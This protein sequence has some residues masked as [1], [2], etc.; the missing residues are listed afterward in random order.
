MSDGIVQLQ[1]NSSGPKVDASE[2][3]VGTNIVERQRINISDATS[4][5]GLAGVTAAN[6]LQV[7]VTRVQGTIASTQSGAWNVT[8]TAA[9]PAGANSI[10]VVQQAA[11]V[12]GAQ[13]ATG[14]S[15]QDLKDAGRTPI[16]LYAVA[17][18]A[19]ATGV[20]TAISLTKLSGV[21]STVSGASFVISA[22]KTFRITS[23]FLATRGSATA[24]AQSTTF[25]FRLNA[26]GAVTTTSAP[27]FLQ[28]RSVTPAT[29]SAWD[30]LALPLP[31]G[32]EIVGNGTLQIGVTAIS[33]FVTNAP[34]LDVLIT[35]YEY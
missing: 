24:T 26:T 2:L 16:V 13:G 23:I 4:A 12:K 27:V 17:A 18:V 30:R 21:A 8:L 19:G 29:A 6:G 25:S 31:D 20:E 15:T 3:T 35:G 32:F 22:G 28:S 7:D 1:P 10:G 5:T 14:I 33:T 34:T 9:L 11:L